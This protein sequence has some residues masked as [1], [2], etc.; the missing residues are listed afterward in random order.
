MPI[1]NCHIHGSEEKN[2]AQ[3]LHH[4][5]SNAA[6]AVGEKVHFGMK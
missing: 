5:A 1:A 3:R 6:A 2:W 4:D